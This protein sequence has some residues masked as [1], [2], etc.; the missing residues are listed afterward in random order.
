MDERSS[1]DND[2]TD[3]EEDDEDGISDTFYVENNEDD[4]EEGDIRSKTTE[5]VIE[6]NLVKET[7]SLTDTPMEV[8]DRRIESD[9]RGEP[10]RDDTDMVA[11]S[12]GG[13][14]GSPSGILK[15][16]NN[17]A[18]TGCFGPFPNN[19]GLNVI[20]TG[21][22]DVNFD[23][24]QD[25]KRRIFINVNDTPIASSDPSV[26]HASLDLNKCLSPTHVPLPDTVP[27]SY[28]RSSPRHYG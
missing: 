23:S 25:K 10:Q 22:Q 8:V 18:K 27:K 20:Q 13:L 7:T 2:K 9:S 6:S 3:C 28:P 15:N 24:A 19:M 12:N 5:A 17:L 11:N 16:L 26:P 21:G 14:G 4:L 1:S